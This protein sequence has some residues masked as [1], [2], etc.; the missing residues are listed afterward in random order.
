MTTEKPQRPDI[1]RELIARATESAAHRATRV[2]NQLDGVQLGRGRHTDYANAKFLHR[3]LGEY[4][5]PGHRLVGPA[6]ARAA[7]SIALHSDHDLVFQRAATILLGRAVEVGDALV[8][9]WAHLHDRTLINT[10]QDQEYGTQLLLSSDRIELCPLRAPGSVDKRRATV[11]L[12][13][14]AVALETVRSRYMPNG[15]TDEVPSVVLAE[16]A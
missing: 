6:A 8:H 9:H 15:S 11:G 7:W 14:I 10:G 1:A 5:W 13:P 3:V 16:A 2:R 4:E 12:P